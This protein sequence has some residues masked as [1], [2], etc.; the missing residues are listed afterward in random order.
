[1]FWRAKSGS[2]GIDDTDM[3]YI[4]FGKGNFLDWVMD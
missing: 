3:D 2:V 1:M 4:S